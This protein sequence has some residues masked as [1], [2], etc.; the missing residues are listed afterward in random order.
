MRA[1]R[2]AEYGMG[3]QEKFRNSFTDNTVRDSGPNVKQSLRTRTKP[4]PSG[5]KWLTHRASFRPINKLSTSADA[6]AG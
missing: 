4:G 1:S 6:A 3:C 2:Y 5:A